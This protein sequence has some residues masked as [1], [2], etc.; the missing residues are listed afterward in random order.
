MRQVDGPDSWS[1]APLRASA[2]LMIHPEESTMSQLNRRWVAA[3]VVAAAV[4]LLFGRS[5]TVG[6]QH[7]GRPSNWVKVGN[8]RIN[9]DA[10]HY[11][12]D[13]GKDLIIDFGLPPGQI[14]LE[15]AGAEA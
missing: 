1:L 7:A 2:P 3:A 4:L 12:L 14:K 13:E 10:I 9:G 11:T 15:G 5:G 8:Y 6:A